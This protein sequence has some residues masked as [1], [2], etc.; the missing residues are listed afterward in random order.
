M[1]LAPNHNKNK[2]LHTKIQNNT[3]KIGLY[4]LLLI[5]IVPNIDN[6]IN[7]SNDP[8]IANTPNNLSGI[9]LNIQ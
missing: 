2:K 9:D 6:G 3:C 8:N 5:L 7:I 1:G 4:L